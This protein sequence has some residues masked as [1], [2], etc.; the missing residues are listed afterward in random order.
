MPR[1]QQ[2]CVWAYLPHFETLHLLTSSLILSALFSFT[3]LIQ[4]IDPLVDRHLVCIRHTPKLSKNRLRHDRSQDFSGAVAKEV[5]FKGSDL[6]GSRFFKADLK[7]ADF[8]GANLG[9]ASL[10]EADLEG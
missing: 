5:N 8:T 3:V 6:R 2:S 1:W 10:E 9:T 4:Q 7:Q